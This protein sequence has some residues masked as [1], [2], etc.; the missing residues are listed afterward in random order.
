MEHCLEYYIPGWHLLQ[1]KYLSNPATM[2][3]CEQFSSLA[4]NIIQKNRAALSLSN[5]N[6][7]ICLIKCVF[8]SGWLLFSLYFYIYFFSAGLVVLYSLSTVTTAAASY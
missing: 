5:A 8:G 4:G 2:M 3:P 7:V 1:R 6:K